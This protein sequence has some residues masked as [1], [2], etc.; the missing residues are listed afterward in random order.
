MRVLVTGA[1][2]FVGSHLSEAL[3]AM[4]HDVA[5]LVRPGS[6]PR[7]LAGTGLAMADCGM[8]SPEAM[9]EA[10]GGAE[11]IFHV[12][13]V[14]KAYRAQ[15]YYD[16]NVAIARNLAEAV[17]RYG[18]DVRCLVGVS[19]QAAGGPYAGPDGADES[20]APEPV[21]FYGRAKLEVESVLGGLRDGLALGIVRP[22]MVYG[23]RDTAFVP[24]YKGALM[25]LFPVPGSPRMRMSIVHVHDLVRGMIGLGEA[26]SDGRAASG[27]VYYLSGQIATWKEIGQAIGQAVGHGQLV[28]PIPLPLIRVIATVNQLAGRMGLPTSHLVVDKWREAK[29]PGWVCSHA[30]AAADFGYAPRVGLKQG[31]RETVAWCRE[32]GLIR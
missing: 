11:M 14:T 8:D 2:G 1:A 3:A 24:L 23:P 10:V 9:K 17:R 6:A 12:A 21:S 32:H 19:S 5:C 18:K 13:G 29:Q 20:A 7:W 4:G 28:I 25:G 26:L 16:G 22:P 31:L 27:G 30:R 15:G